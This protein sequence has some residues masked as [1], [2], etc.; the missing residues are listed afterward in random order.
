MYKIKW[1]ALGDR[2]VTK[3]FACSESFKFWQVPDE[4]LDIKKEMAAVQVRQ[5]ASIS[6]VAECCRRKLLGVAGD[7]EKSLS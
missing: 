2:E 3:Q 7:C 4:S 5:Q 6:S 1:E